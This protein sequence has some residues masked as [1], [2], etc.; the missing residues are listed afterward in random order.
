MI[1][2]CHTHLWEF[3]GHLS[4]AFVEEANARSR[5]HRLNMH[6]PPESHWPAMANVDRVIVFGLR[7]FHSGLYSPNEYIAEYAGLHPEK[8]I[9]FAS[10]DPTVDKLADLEYAID[11]LGLS[12]LKLGPI[13][14][15]IHPT[16]PR[17]LAVYDFCETRRIPILIHQGTTFPRK[18]PLKYSFPVMLED[19]AL[20]FPELRMVIAHLGHPW[21]SE[22]LVLI[23]KQ[24]HFYSDISALHYRP[25]QFY[26]ALITAREYGVLDKLLFGSDFPFT[27]PDATIEALRGFNNIVE[28]T[29][30]PR[31]SED[32]IEALIHSPTLDYLG[33]NK[34]SEPAVKES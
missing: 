5:G 8:V 19:V 28:G 16:D 29:N 3:P 1:V 4:D 11:Q 25:W 30:L 10:L 33:L 23:R 24:P 26:N 27:T 21:I 18:A 14:Q 13:Y 34:Y 7:A 2:D 9:G 31:L 20:Q 15:N 12:G 17:L 6:A 32:E 22:T